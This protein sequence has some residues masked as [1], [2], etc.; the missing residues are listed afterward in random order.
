MG[1]RATINLDNA[2]EEDVGAGE[3]VILSMTVWRSVWN[4]IHQLLCGPH[5]IESL[6]C[7]PFRAIEKATEYAGREVI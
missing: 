2:E 5:Y 1:L 4:A 6:P 3:N 7:I